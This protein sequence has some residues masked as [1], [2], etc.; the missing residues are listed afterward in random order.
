LY[1]AH[2]GHLGHCCRARIAAT[3]GSLNGAE[4]IGKTGWAVGDSGKVFRLQTGTN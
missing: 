3:T 1:A 2:T 4:F